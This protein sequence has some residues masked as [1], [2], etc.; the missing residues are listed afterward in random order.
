M[1]SSVKERLSLQNNLGN[2]MES[3]NFDEDD[4]EK[5]NSRKSKGGYNWIRESLISSKKQ[6]PDMNY[7]YGEVINENKSLKKELTL[8]KTTIHNIYAELEYLRRNNL[9]VEKIIKEEIYL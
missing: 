4:R 9:D 7:F 1:D 3:I 5:S 2:L 8:Y 6:T